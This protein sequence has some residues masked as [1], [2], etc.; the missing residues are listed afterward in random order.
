MASS[1]GQAAAPPAGQG[2]LLQPSCPSQGSL[3]AWPLHWATGICP[4]LAGA[5]LP[6]QVV[7]VERTIPQAINL[8]AGVLPHCPLNKR[9]SIVRQSLA[10]QFALKFVQLACFREMKFALDAASPSSKALHA[11]VAWGV[12][13]VPAQSAIYALAIAGT[14]QHFGKLPPGGSGGLREFVRLKIMPGILWTFLREGF[15]TGGGLTIGPKVQEQLDAAT[16]GALPSWSTKFLGG[17]L[18]GWACAFATMLPHNCALTAAR[19]AQQGESPTTLSC[20]RTCLREQGPVRM[21]T[22]NFQQRCAVIA[23]VVACLNT[24]QVLSEPELAAV[25]RLQAR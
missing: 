2:G 10:P 5:A 21:A 17:L 22:V 13:N 23:V 6:I 9:L 4:R 16:G 3:A 11:P 7:T 8:S 14:Y 19:M 18:A 20:F 1:S 15:A 25:A 12:T 24:A